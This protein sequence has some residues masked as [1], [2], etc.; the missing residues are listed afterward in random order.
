MS[1]LPTTGG[2]R[3]DS[4]PFHADARIL[5]RVEFTRKVQAEF[6]AVDA[7]RDASMSRAS[8]RSHKQSRPPA[9]EGQ[10]THTVTT[11]GSKYES[12]EQFEFLVSVLVQARRARGNR[13]RLRNPAMPRKRGDASMFKRVRFHLRKLARRA[14]NDLHKVGHPVPKRSALTEALSTYVYSELQQLILIRAPGEP[15]PGKYDRWKMLNGDDAV[16]RVAASAARYTL[17]K[18]DSDFIEEMQRR[19]AKGGRNSKRGPSKATADNIAALAALPYGTTIKQAATALGVSESTIK[20]MYKNNR[21]QDA[22]ATG[23]TPEG[24]APHAQPTRRQELPQALSERW[25]QGEVETEFREVLASL[26]AYK[27][28]TGEWY[29][30]DPD[31]EPI[32]LASVVDEIQPARRAPSSFEQRDYA[33]ERTAEEGRSLQRV[34]SDE[35]LAGL[36]L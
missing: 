1:S 16:S 14:L 32:M 13:K 7:R 10:L 8:R 28:S 2:A 6:A 9:T 27:L 22:A 25:Q 3:R 26:G 11:V 15:K 17:R 36:D 19:G 4:G 20:R 24:S 35:F 12:E 31:E 33:A 29:L 5:R 21:E 30:A 34:T 18:W 23:Q